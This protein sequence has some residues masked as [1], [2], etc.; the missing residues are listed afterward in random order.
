[1]NNI[2]LIEKVEMLPLA[3]QSQVSD[4]V[5]FLLNRHFQGKAAPPDEPELTA[6]QKAE[7]DKRY[8]EYLDDPDSAISI[9]VLKTRLM[10]KYGLQHQS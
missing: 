1:M 2:Q 4:F 3:L 6:E 9:E 10:K 5:D 8:Q 7:L